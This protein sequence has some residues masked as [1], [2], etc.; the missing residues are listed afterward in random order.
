MTRMKIKFF[1]T[2]GTIDKVYFDKK[3]DYQVG[4]PKIVSILKE[5][6]INFDYDYESLMRK[7]SIDMTDDDRRLIYNKVLAD[8]HDRIIITHGTDTMAETGTVLKSITGKVI[9]LTGAIEPAEFKT[10]DAAFNIGAAIAA[11]QILHPG[12]Y[13]AMN[14]R[15]Y[16]PD[17]VQKNRNRNRFEEL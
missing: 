2:G 9:V 10:S 8:A 15:I 12:V 17:R 1:T 7:D 14:G 13:I 16:D 3:S 11:V 5:M 4:K 6:N